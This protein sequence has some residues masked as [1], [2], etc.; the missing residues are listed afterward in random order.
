[1]FIILQHH[2]QHSRRTDGWSH[3]SQSHS[4][5]NFC[6]LHPVLPK[7]MFMFTHILSS[8]MIHFWSFRHH[9]A[10]Q[11]HPTPPRT[12]TNF[13]SH[14]PPNHLH[15]NQPHCTVHSY[16]ALDISLPKP[17]ILCITHSRTVDKGLGIKKSTSYFTY[18]I[19][20]T[21]IFTLVHPPVFLPEC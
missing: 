14:L 3:P 5:S 15:Y 12:L 9:L 18:F 16:T 10:T 8:R 2:F 4:K 21:K 19:A 17:I 13:L 1:M 20:Y 11:P 6:P 7:I